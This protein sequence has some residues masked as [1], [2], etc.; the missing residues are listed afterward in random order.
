M[1]GHS[2][3]NSISV[4]KPF[5]CFCFSLPSSKFGWKASVEWETVRYPSSRGWP[6]SGTRFSIFQ[7]HA[8]EQIIKYWN[9][10]RRCQQPSNHRTAMVNEWLVSG[11]YNEGFLTLQDGISRALTE[12]I[13]QKDVSDV[14]IVM[15]RFPY[16]PY[17]TDLY[18]LALQGWLPFIIVI[19]FIY[20]AL[21]IAKSIV[22]E[23]EK[24]LKVSP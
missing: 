16:P 5:V 15:R 20:P 7:D 23:K 6:S 19:S 12:T 3:F 2:T 1:Y 14:N 8:E 21:N 17:A 9:P 18:L 22:H 10:V 24:R 4:S 13:S 11:Y